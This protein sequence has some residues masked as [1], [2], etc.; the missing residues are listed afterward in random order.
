MKLN[1]PIAASSLTLL[2]VAL[3]AFLLDVPV[4]SAVQ[5]SGAQPVAYADF[6]IDLAA[7][8]A[9]TGQVDSNGKPL[10]L[11]TP[12]ATVSAPTLG[13][14]R[15]VV[16]EGTTSAV[17]EQGP[18]HLRSSVLPGQPGVSVLYGRAWAYGGP[19]RDLEELAAGDALTL[20]TGQGTHTYTVTG[21][22]R[23][24]ETAPALPD[25]AKGEGRLTLVTASGGAF[26]PSNVVYVDAKLTSTPVAPGPRVLGR[27]SLLA[28]E[29]PLAGDASSWPI[30]LL[31]L[32]ALA[33][34]AVALAW[35]MKRFGLAQ[36]WLVGV[37]VVA[38]FTLLASREATRLLPNLL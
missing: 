16:F 33:L 9:P 13:L 32:Q 28:A 12:V 22:R 8:T 11:G 30:L 3:L 14:V 10:A 4:L 27:A 7:A 6:R 1:R 17:L 5:H 38:L 31:L 20:V 21:L 19:F 2:A 15:E 23:P 36:A 24:G 18:G 35:A 34:A 37:P 25:V 26:M 29:N